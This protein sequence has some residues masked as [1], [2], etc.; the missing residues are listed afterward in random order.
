MGLTKDL[1]KG[2]AYLDTAPFIYFIE[3]HKEYLSVVESVFH[4]IAQGKLQAFTSA[5]TLAEVWVIPFRNN[6]PGLA[7]KYEEFLSRSKGL[8]LVDIDRFVLKEAAYLRA[9]SYVKMPDAIQIATALRCGC[10]TLITNDRDLPQISGLK[11]LQLNN[12]V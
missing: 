12:Y 2:P 10:T 5:L 11:I 9:M 3:E 7:Q 6:N 8:H 4:G 1:G